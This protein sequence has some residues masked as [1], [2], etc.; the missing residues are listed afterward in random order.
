MY[1]IHIDVWKKI[2]KWSC[3]ILLSPVIILFLTLYQITIGVTVVLLFWFVFLVPVLMFQAIKYGIQPA[4][5]NETKT[6]LRNT[7]WAESFLMLWWLINYAAT[8]YILR[9]ELTLR[10]IIVEA[11]YFLLTLWF[12]VTITLNSINLKQLSMFFNPIFMILEFF[13]IISLF[14]VIIGLLVLS[15]IQWLWKLLDHFKIGYDEELKNDNNQ[16]DT[17]ENENPE[18]IKI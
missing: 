3:I 2:W 17:D 12:F 11:F 18:Y 14:E 15:I 10:M 9:D 8:G 6:R 16:K 1:K 4:N 13:G 5:E 7:I